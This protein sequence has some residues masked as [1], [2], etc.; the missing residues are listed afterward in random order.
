M[1]NGRYS[2]F[3]IEEDFTFTVNAA[4][5]Y[6]S[7][8]VFS[9]VTQDQFLIALRLAFTQSILNSRTAADKYCLLMDE[10]I[11]SSDEFR[12][13]AIFEVLNLAKETFPQIL[14]IA[15]EDISNFVDYH[16][17]LERN[18]NGYASLISKSWGQLRSTDEIKEHG[19]MRPREWRP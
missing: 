13:Q 17:T 19:L 16:L 2:D 9:G 7:R 12:Q 10:C 5:E 14:V 6:K 11:S 15:H 3:E 1:T 4:G 8:E 18:E